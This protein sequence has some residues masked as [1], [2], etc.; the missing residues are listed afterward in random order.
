MQHVKIHYPEPG[1]KEKNSLVVPE[2]REV[3]EV[4]VFKPT[5]GLETTTQMCLR[6]GVRPGSCR[7]K[8]RPF[9]G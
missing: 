2:G 9:M 4:W 6:S 8:I 5:W 7:V 1:S 3:S